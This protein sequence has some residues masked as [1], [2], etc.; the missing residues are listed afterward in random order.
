MTARKLT[1]LTCVTFSLC[2]CSSTQAVVIFSETF[3]NYTGFPSSSNDT[4]NHRT[5]YGVPTV[6]EGADSPLWLGGRL[7][8]GNG[9]ISSDVG[10]LQYADGRNGANNTPAGRVDDDAGLV[11]RI[12][13]TQFFDPTLSFD[14]RTFSLETNDRFV[15]AYYIGDDLGLPNGTYDWFN[16]PARGNGDMS[17]S[18]PN[19]AANPWYQANWTEVLRSTSPGGFTNV[20]PITLSGAGGNVIYLAF[21]LDNGEK[22]LGKVDNILVEAQQVPEPTTFVMAGMGAVGLA[23]AA[24]RRRN[25][26]ATARVC[27]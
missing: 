12:D 17:G 8:F 11:A 5:N 6:A 9:S 25:R 26:V 14:F 19:G 27:A 21:W 15:A 2:A 3:D 20:G 16:D 22:D 13:L 4:G 24:L 1:A 23:L 18:D 10:V 7:E